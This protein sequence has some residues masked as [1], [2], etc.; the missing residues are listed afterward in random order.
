MLSKYLT[1]DSFSFV[2]Q[3]F[4]LS[5]SADFISELGLVCLF[6]EISSIF[7]MNS[8]QQL[9]LLGDFKY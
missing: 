8:V 4:F 7:L 3:N 2:I 6:L 1:E 9:Q 5:S